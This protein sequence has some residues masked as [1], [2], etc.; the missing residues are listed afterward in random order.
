MHKNLIYPEG[1]EPRMF[2]LNHNMLKRS[3]SIECK[4]TECQNVYGDDMW[5]CFV[6]RQLGFHHAIQV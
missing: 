6:G 4:V 1:D 3:L 2:M 5:I